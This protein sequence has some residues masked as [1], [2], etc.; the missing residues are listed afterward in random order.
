MAPLP[1][2]RLT[3]CVRAFTFTG[4]DYF[5]PMLVTVRRRHEKRYGALFTC[6]TKRAVHLELA[7]SLSADSAIMAIRRMISRRG[8][9]RKIFS[10]NGTNFRGAD[11][12]LKEA[13]KELDV[14]QVGSELASGGID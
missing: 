2:V 3:S 7:A 4:L 11:A 6:L 8:Q 5:G 14:E 10:D 1:A 12:E 9:P 13:L